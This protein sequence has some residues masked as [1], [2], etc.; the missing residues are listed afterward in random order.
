M[1]VRQEHI[2][3]AAIPILDPSILSTETI[4]LPAEYN[5]N[6]PDRVMNIDCP[7][8]ARSDGYVVMGAY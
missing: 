6:K 4:C 8:T 2:S 1:T 3:I 5:A 7:K